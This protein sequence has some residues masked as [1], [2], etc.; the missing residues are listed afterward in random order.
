M[1][2]AKEV[3]RQRVGGSVVGLAMA[4]DRELV[5][6]AGDDGFLHLLG[7]GGKPLWSVQLGSKPSAL[8]ISSSGDFAAAGMV[9]GSVLFFD[10]SGK[11]LWKHDAGEPVTR[12]ALSH[13]ARYMLVGTERGGILFL[14]C[15]T[16]RVVWSKRAE[17]PVPALGLSSSASYAVA[18][19]EDST[20]YFMDNYS[21]NY[22]GRLAW[23]QKMKG[24]IGHVA[25]SADGFYTAVASSD[26]SVH[27]IDR[28]GKLYWSHRLESPPGSLAISPSGDYIAV[29]TYGGAHPGQV[30]FFHRTEGLLWRYIT[31]EKTVGTVAM[32]SR[33]VFIAAG[34]EA[35]EIFLFH[36]NQKLVWKQRLEGPVENVTLSPDGKRLVAATG[37]GVVFCFDTSSI[38]EALRPRTEEAVELEPSLFRPMRAPPARSGLRET[39]GVAGQDRAGAVRVEERKEA[40]GLSRDARTLLEVIVD[41]C[42]LVVLGLILTVFYFTYTGGIEPGVGITLLIFLL[43]VMGALLMMLYK[44]VITGPKKKEP[45]FY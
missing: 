33:G 18:G 22:G 4:G 43:V 44:Y 25:L 31:G 27:L 15:V 8:G 14:S 1:V 13:N 16:G 32:D 36:R 24:A 7:A 17:G 10:G 5:L 26:G 35:E 38:V 23:S 42:L 34:T 30:S 37:K 6:A 39:T 9:D 2:E 20:V 28:L 40:A 19:S 21:T 11:L 41:I 45:S 12:L 29:G 3:W